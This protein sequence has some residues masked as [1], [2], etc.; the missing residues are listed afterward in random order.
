MAAKLRPASMKKHMTASTRIVV[1]PMTTRISLR[2]NPRWQVRFRRSIDVRLES[3]ACNKGAIGSTAGHLTGGP[4]DPDYHLPH[5]GAVAGG[6]RDVG[7]DGG[8]YVFD[9]AIR[10]I[11][12]IVSTI[13]RSEE[14]MPQA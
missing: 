8:N 6:E 2:T 10:G 9:S 7:N 5:V 12:Y 11:K 1:I 14:H 13:I 3:I 4:I